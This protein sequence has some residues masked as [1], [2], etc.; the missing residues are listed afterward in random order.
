MEGAATG[1]GKSMTIMTTTSRQN[2]MNSP[3]RGQSKWW[4]AAGVFLLVLAVYI[5]SGPGRIDTIDGQYRFNVTY[6]WLVQGRPT[7]DDAWITMG[8]VGRDG[9]HYSNYGV[10][11]SIFPMPLVW[12]ALRSDT[13]VQETSRFLFSLTSAFFGAGIAAILFLFYVE[14]GL[15]LRQ[16]WFW[17]MISS[18]TTLLWPSAASS[19]ENAQRA[20]FA[21][22]GVYLGFLSAKYSSYTLALFGGLTAGILM[23]YQEFHLLIIPALACCTL[24]W[25]ARWQQTISDSSS[26]QRRSIVSRAVTGVGRDLLQLV[27]IFRSALQRPGVERAAGLRYLIWSVTALVSGLS[28]SFVYNY[29]R[30]GSFSNPG[31]VVI[32]QTTRPDPLYGNPLIG[33]LTLVVSPGKSIFLYSP[34]LILCIAGWYYFRRRKPEIAFAILASSVILLLLLSFISFAGGDWCW[35]PRYL[36]VLLPLWAIALPFVWLDG[37]FPRAVLLGVLGMGLL[38]QILALSAENQRFFFA[39]GVEDHFWVKD[40][41]FYFK[42]SALVARVGETVSLTEGV[43]TTANLFSSIPRPGW[44]TYAILGPPEYFPRSLSPQWMQHFKIYYLPRPW[45]LW[46]TWIDRELRPI[47]LQSWLMSLLATFLAGAGMI[48]RGLRVDAPA[49]RRDH[50]VTVGGQESRHLMNVAHSSED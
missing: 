39:R 16:A 27:R 9:L 50:Y 1:R 19:F 5:L 3:N 2:P 12:L 4:T 31:K 23:T 46:M 40:P 37:R 20:F 30:F 44:L 34:P 11:G 8:Y 47:N 21:L 38:V 6:H 17:A 36:V 22:A 13:P 14:L 24:G 25:S 18:F 35:G 29:V 45:P 15:S 43:P 41:W 49:E 32:S 7:V 33:F 26:G 48:C 28:I 10:P 42:H